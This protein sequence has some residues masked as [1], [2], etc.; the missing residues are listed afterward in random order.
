MALL[1]Y[2][3]ARA[4]VG[5]DT[6]EIDEEIARRVLLQPQMWPD[7]YHLMERAGIV[8]RV[9]RY[10]EADIERVEDERMEPT[11]DT[12]DVCSRGRGEEHERAMLGSRW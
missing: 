1:E 2:R 12:L 3:Q 11:V 9:R 7:L 6:H 4:L 10:R 5:L 8:D